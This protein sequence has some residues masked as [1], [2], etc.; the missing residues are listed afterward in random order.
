[1]RGTFAT[2]ASPSRDA[3]GI[4]SVLLKP[5]DPLFEK[6]PAGGVVPVGIGETYSNPSYGLA[7]KAKK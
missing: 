7:L 1:L 3:G 4:D 6:K 5:L 2:E